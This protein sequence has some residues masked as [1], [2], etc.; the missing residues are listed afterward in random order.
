MHVLVIDSIKSGK[1]PL[2]L[3]SGKKVTEAASGS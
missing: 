1:W 2:W 3:T